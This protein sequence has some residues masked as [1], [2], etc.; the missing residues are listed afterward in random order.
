MKAWM[1]G[2]TLMFVLSLGAS[3]EVMGTPNSRPTPQRKTP[4]PHK[5]AA[6]PHKAPSPRRKAPTPQRKAPVARRK[7][8]PLQR[9]VPLN[10]SKVPSPKRKAPSVARPRLPHQKAVGC[11]EG[12]LVGPDGKGLEKAMVFTSP[13]TSNKFTSAADGGRFM[14]C[15]RR[16]MWQVGGSHI[17]RRAIPGGRYTVYA[18]KFGFSVPPVQVMFKRLTIK[19]PL[20]KATPLKKLCV[21][22]RPQRRKG[23]REGLERL[24]WPNGAVKLE[25]HY[26]AGA[27]HGP[28]R[29]FGRDGRPYEQGV[30]HEGRLHGLYTRWDAKGQVAFKVPFVKGM[31]KGAK[32]SKAGVHLPY[33]L[34]QLP[35]KRLQRLI[36]MLREDTSASKWRTQPW[37]AWIRASQDG[38]HLT[39]LFRVPTHK[40]RWQVRVVAWGEKRLGGW[41]DHAWIEKRPSG[42]IVWSMASTKSQQSGLDPRNRMIDTTITLP[43]GRYRLHYRTNESHSPQQWI[44]TPPATPHHY[45]ITLYHPESKGYKLLLP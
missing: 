40:K 30:F 16:V 3:H 20:M 42:A 6:P 4:T 12:Q 5:A 2:L 39:R 36:Q 23:K 14:I 31:P 7:A 32:V 34:D 8:A 44:T 37:W 22:A 43:P 25:R 21:S 10:R 33:G 24:C 9:K 11:L 13:P 38:Q 1:L 15:F 19:L 35:T 45:G 29:A 26:K 27:L 28:Y 41:V 17:L 18:T